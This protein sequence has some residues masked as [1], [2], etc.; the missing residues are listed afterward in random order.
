MKLPRSLIALPVKW[1]VAQTG[2]YNIGGGP[3]A[4]TF[5]AVNTWT[6]TYLA[7]TTGGLTEDAPTDLLRLVQAGLNVPSPGLWT[8][9]LNSSGYVE[10]VYNGASPT[11]GT[12]TLSTAIARALGFAST[13]V[14]PLAVAAV[15][16]ATMHP[17]FCWIP[18]SLANDTG[19]R[20]SATTLIAARRASGLVD[21]WD[22]GV[23]AVE[24]G[25]AAR[26]A[27]ATEAVRTSRSMLATPYYPPDSEPS[28]WFAPS[29]VPESCP[30]A[31]TVHE[32]L[33]CGVGLRLAYV[34]GSLQSLIAGTSSAYY[35]GAFDPESIRTAEQ[36]EALSVPAFSSLIDVPNVV[37]TL[38]KLS[39]QETR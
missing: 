22:E 37:L 4:V 25:V 15:A 24:R 18:Y 7:P 13:T 10:I 32:T 38:A 6:R 23:Q 11:T 3:V 30:V 9:R 34:I 29:I 36:R 5:V 20:P 35:V 39:T 1:T 14:G 27:P 12:I 16:T 26:F 17:A 33:S 31:W 21:S 28:R 8:V 2:S 19:W